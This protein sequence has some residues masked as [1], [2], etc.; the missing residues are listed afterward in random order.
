MEKHI[1]KPGKLSPPADLRRDEFDTDNERIL[2]A[3]ETVDI[4][5]IGDS[6]TE[7]WNVRQA[8]AGFGNVVN[9]GISGD[10]IDIIE[11]RFA[12]DVLQLK[13]RMAV[14]H[15]GVNNTF[16]FFET[17]EEDMPAAIE[18]AVNTF[19][20]SYEAMF[21]A[22][23]QA[24]QRVI[25]CTI[26]PL[27]E[28]PSPGA[29]AR[30]RTV[31]RMNGELLRLCAQYGVPCADYHTPLAE[32]DG[33]TAQPCLTYDGLHPHDSGYARMDRVIRPILTAALTERS[34]LRK[35]HV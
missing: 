19:V 8:F 5:F 21:E 31:V 13:P 6:I 28:Q 24:G 9:R 16:P 33:L 20:A 30:K 17:A 11:K 27:S 25:A 15:G 2:T 18:K 23:R 29:L 14:I 4:V 1:L 35:R 32:F 26:T 34:I 22:C 3:E 7:G 12:A 10:V